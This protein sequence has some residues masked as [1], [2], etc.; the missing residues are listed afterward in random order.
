[1]V[2]C[3]KCGNQMDNNAKFCMECGA[4]LTDNSFKNNNAFQ[5][6]LQN[7]SS[8][9]GLPESFDERRHQ[10]HKEFMA[11]LAAN[12]ASIKNND[13]LETYLAMMGDTKHRDINKIIEI[14][15]HVKGGDLDLNKADE[16]SKKILEDIGASSHEQKQI[17]NIFD[18]IIQRS[19][20][21]NERKRTQ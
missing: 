16:I 6:L 5:D 17:I 18:S 21:S 4:K 9:G 1:M 2:F 20:N 14:Y 3:P 19:F 11:F 15:G 7:L 10:R 13:P 8:N 12:T